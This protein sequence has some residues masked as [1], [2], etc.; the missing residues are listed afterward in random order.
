[1]VLVADSQA[2]GQ[3]APPPPGQGSRGSS[4]PGGGKILGLPAPVAIG[5]AAAL[6]A[7]GFMWWR[8]HR[9]A[10]ATSGTTSATR[11]SST[12]STDVQGELG[13]LQSEID[14]LL[15][16]QDAGGGGGTGT[17]TTAKTTSPTTTKTT[18][19]AHAPKPGPVSDIVVTNKSPTSVV[20]SWR[21]PQFSSKAPASTTYLFQIKGKDPAAHNIGS[22][23]SY[24]VGGLKKG[25]AYTVVVTPS[26]GP[27][28][29]K[30]FTTEK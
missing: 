23:T 14:E 3:G 2:A 24:N 4:R 1:M 17:G 29:S 5:G 16:S 20:V 22:R 27:A 18:T 8:S 26:G 9:S 28:T 12:S 30:T 15:G 11:T 21:P 7:L 19:T 10:A 13:E 25:T 6:A